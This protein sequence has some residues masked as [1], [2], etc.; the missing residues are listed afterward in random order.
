MRSLLKF[1]VAAALGVASVTAMSAPAH[2]VDYCNGVVE[3]DG[4]TY[5]TNG[6]GT[7]ADVAQDPFYCNN[8]Y[9]GYYWASCSFYAGGVCIVGRL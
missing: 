3:S 8:H 4:C 1:F 7:A 5:C 9:A 6:S 2:A